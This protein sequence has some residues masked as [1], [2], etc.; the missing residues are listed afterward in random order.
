MIIVD[1][2]A[3]M[4]EAAN[5]AYVFYHEEA[6]MLNVKIDGLSRGDSFV[7]VDAVRT[8]TITKDRFGRKF[9]TWTAQIYFS[10]FT[11]FGNDMRANPNPGGRVSS[12]GVKNDEI[13]EAIRTEIVYPFLR[14]LDAPDVRKSLNAGQEWTRIPVRRPPS[15][16]D[17]NEISYLLELPVV[18]PIC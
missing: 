15:R 18:M 12:H 3:A 8:G 5:P 7:W 11:D 9:E 17:G 1:K 2:I 10:K 4:C 16:F 13:L 6:D 14:L